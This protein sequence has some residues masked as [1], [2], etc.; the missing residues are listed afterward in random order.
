MISNESRTESRRT[1]F[2]VR[3]LT[4]RHLPTLRRVGLG[5]LVL[6]AAGAMVGWHAV[7]DEQAT[8]EAAAPLPVTTT[9]LA[10]QESASLQ[11]G[12]TGQVVA[13]RSSALSFERSGRLVSVLVDDGDRV[14]D[15][16]VLALLDTEPLQIQRREL[17]AQRAAAQARLDELVAGPRS[18]RL[19]LAAAQVQEAEARADMAI[20][21]RGR[22][23]DLFE[24][25]M[26]TEKEHQ[27]SIDQQ[28]AAEAQLTQARQAFQ[29]LRNG[30][31]AEQID[32]QRAAVAQLDAAIERV[33]MNLRKS[34]LVAPFAGSI[35]LRYFDEGVV[36]AAGQPVVSMLEDQR[37]EARVGVPVSTVSRLHVGDDH[38][39]TIGHREL[40]ARVAAI[41]PELD[42]STR[43]RTVVLDLPAD[44]HVAPGEI[45]RLH[46]PATLDSAGFWVPT[47]ALIKSS[48]GI[49]G[50]LR[51]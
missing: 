9:L 2:F 30:T 39:L 43:T 38:R 1:S 31:R 16:Q 6:S 5:V 26:A 15:R 21:E 47:T 25:D 51:Y 37:L 24:R 36:V 19:A 49:V 17:V 45:A 3:V 40:T 42:Q 48:R 33:D 7:G 14:A 13:S 28:A 34:R 20:R 44:A 22:I 35:S 29:E 23:E 50:G 10:R 11:R 32:A 12:Y 8:I 41:L 46:L 4:T 18:E 27:D